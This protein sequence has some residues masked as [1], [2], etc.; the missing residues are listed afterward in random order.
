M[1][2]EPT[3]REANYNF[4]KQVSAAR[5]GNT[6]G[7]I[8][9]FRHAFSATTL[10]PLRLQYYEEA[11]QYY[12]PGKE[13]K[14]NRLLPGSLKEA[15]YEIGAKEVLNGIEC[16][17]IQRTND[18]LWIAPHH[19]FVVCKR[20][21]SNE[22]G[23][24]VERVANEDLR[25]VSKGVWFPFRQT[26]EIFEPSMP[27]GR[28]FKITVETSNVEV[29]KTE[30]ADLEVE[31]DKDVR[32]IEDH[33]NKTTS[34]REGNDTDPFDQSIENVTKGGGHLSRWRRLGQP[35]KPTIIWLNLI[36][37]LC[38]VLFVVSRRVYQLARACPK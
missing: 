30:I 24:L 38:A 2:L 1:V 18:R 27:D 12:V 20:E 3:F 9:N 14:L 28:L 23:I 26:Q 35:D 4:E 25:E 29:G 10:Y 7:Q 37:A 34:L 15:G 8:A 16:E 5:E 6:L 22:A 19:S 17:I 33:I 13:N 11:D 36:A 21:S 31:L 32:Y